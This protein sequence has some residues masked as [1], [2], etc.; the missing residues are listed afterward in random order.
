MP[1]Y[2]AK[3]S[4]TAE[5]WAKVIAKPEDRRKALQPVLESLGG[6]LHGFWYAFG[7]A[8]GYVLMEAPDDTS[9][10]AGL[11][12]VAASGAF[13]QVSTTRLLAV[14]DMLEALGKAGSLQFRPPG[15]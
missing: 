13:S 4:L 1:M 12:A 2:L 10:A 5:S 7:D 11:V 9:A 3:F 14:E 8:D 6:K 15:G